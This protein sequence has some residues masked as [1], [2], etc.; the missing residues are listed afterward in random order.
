M[1]YRLPDDGRGAHLHQI[2][3]EV[4]EDEGQL[5]EIVSI[6]VDAG[7]EA[8]HGGCARPRGPVPLPSPADG[9]EALLG[10]EV[11]AAMLVEVDQGEDEGDTKDHGVA[12]GD[13]RA[14]SDGVDG[15][16]AR[17][18]VGERAVG[19]EVGGRMGG[20]GQDALGAVGERAV[21]VEGEVP[22]LERGAVEVDAADKRVARVIAARKG[23][24]VARVQERHRR[25]R[26]LLV[27]RNAEGA[28]VWRG[29]LSN[30]TRSSRHGKTR[31]LLAEGTTDIDR[32]A[33]RLA[34]SAKARLGRKS[35]IESGRSAGSS[36]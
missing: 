11:E 14:G 21:G 22:V 5:G 9:V 10:G 1:A 35:L 30:W 24:E 25:K 17:R 6:D 4:G 8:D 7:E 3:K 20:K 29:W 18:V 26:R 36:L 27:A 2:P 33:Q 34:Q 15:G 31:A 16:V 28:R 19:E 32:T 12:D 23:D 13:A